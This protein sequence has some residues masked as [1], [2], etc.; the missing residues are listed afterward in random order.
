MLG[1]ANDEDVFVKPVGDVELWNAKE[2]YGV[3]DFYPVLD[4]VTVWAHNGSYIPNWLTVYLYDGD[5]NK[6][7]TLTWQ[8]TVTISKDEYSY[9]RLSTSKDCTNLE[10]SVKLYARWL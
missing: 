3:T 4:G 1:R 7:K 5:K 6:V 8:T 9:F 10:Y 2:A